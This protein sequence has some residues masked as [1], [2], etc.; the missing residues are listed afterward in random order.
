[1]LGVEQAHGHA[2]ESEK[3]LR[4]EVRHV[5]TGR[6]AERQQN[7]LEGEQAENQKD[8]DCIQTVSDL[9]QAEE[10]ALEAMK[11][12]DRGMF[13]SACDAPKQWSGFCE[14]CLFM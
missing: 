2:G 10:G 8:R 7:Q 9:Q 5:A 12:L 14:L 11:P 6:N 13:R 4:R 3:R 1:M